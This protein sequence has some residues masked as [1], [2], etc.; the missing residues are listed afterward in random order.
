MNFRLQVAAKIG[1]QSVTNF[2][3]FSEVVDDVF[4]EDGAELEAR[5]HAGYVADLKELAAQFLQEPVSDDDLAELI[6]YLSP[7]P[8]TE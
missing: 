1:S 7:E 6:P 8:M 3:Q 5:S 2:E 4:R